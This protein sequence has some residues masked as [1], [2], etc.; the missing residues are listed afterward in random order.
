LIILEAAAG[1]GKTCSSYELVRSFLDK[2]PDR[3]PLL[4]E[5]SRNRQARLFRYVLLDEID[6]VFPSLSISLVESQVASGNILLIVDGFDELLHRTEAISSDY[7]EVEPMLDT[8]SDLLKKNAKVILTTR[9]TAIFAGDHFHRWIDNHSQE[10]SVFRYALLSPRIEDW[11]SYTRRASIE[12]Q[13]FPLRQL[14]NPVLLA[15]LA[16]QNDEDFEILCNNPEQTVD[17]YFERL[18]QREIERQ[19][20]RMD[21]TEQWDV[22][23]RLSAHMVECDFT[24]ENREYLQLQIIDSNSKVLSQARNRYPTEQR[25]TIDELATKLV[26]HAL[27]DRKGEESDRVGFIND[28]VLGTLVGCSAIENKTDEW[29]AAGSFVE[30]AA[31]AFAPRSEDEKKE[32][33]RKVSFSLEFLPVESQLLCDMILCGNPMRS[34]SGAT[35]TGITFRCTVIG[36]GTTIHD[37]VFFDCSF[38]D[39][40]FCLRSLHSVSFVG[41]RF[42]RCEFE[43][44][45]EESSAEVF[46]AGCTGELERLEKVPVDVDRNDLIGSIDPVVKCE[47]EVLEQFWPPGRPHYW[48]RK[49]VETLYRGHSNKERWAVTEAI[50]SLQRR[51]L[52]LVKG[53]IACMNADG[54]EEIRAM[55]GRGL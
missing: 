18:L 54:L 6:R 24:A 40:R 43:S 28:F 47:K 8:I 50:A 44:D 23:V 9:R 38:F 22:F 49:R 48:P 10:F 5:L 2:F 37:S 20:L 4:I 21:P 45:T 1:Y 30:K 32:L 36:L 26:S 51:Q 55:L 42:Y 7:E 41:C 52:I 29:V 34:L 39:L 53:D 19:D 13:N 16:G 25:P 11:L 17:R 33:W 31:E 35:I 27:M 12:A 46:F 3:I 15:Y 14:S